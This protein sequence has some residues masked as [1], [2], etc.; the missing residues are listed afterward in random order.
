MSDGMKLQIKNIEFSWV[1]KRQI[2]KQIIIMKLLD[3]M[4][5]EM[6]SQI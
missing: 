1:R 4:R 3:V 2:Y 6:G 5:E